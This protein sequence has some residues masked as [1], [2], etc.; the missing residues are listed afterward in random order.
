M[1]ELRDGAIWHGEQDS[2]AKRDGLFDG[3]G[4]GQRSERCDETVELL[5]MPVGEE[6]SVPVLDPQA[7]DG[8]ADVAGANGAERDF[9]AAIWFARG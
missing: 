2:V 9:G 5:R 6:Y 8:A 3:A 1:A 4:L 7:S